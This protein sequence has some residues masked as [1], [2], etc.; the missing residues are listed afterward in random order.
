ME[1]IVTDDPVALLAGLAKGLG[2]GSVV[3]YL[4]PGISELSAPAAPMTPEAG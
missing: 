4:G 2:E 3:P 1:T